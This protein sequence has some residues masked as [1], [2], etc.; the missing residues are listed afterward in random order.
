ME[1]TEIQLHGILFKAHCAHMY[2]R[3]LDCVA[4]RA[5][6]AKRS[7]PVIRVSAGERANQFKDELTVVYFS[8]NT[9]RTAL[10]SCV[11]DA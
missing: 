1:L 2:I 4:P 9:L 5:K 8:A 6:K 3:R 11:K 10:I 7:A